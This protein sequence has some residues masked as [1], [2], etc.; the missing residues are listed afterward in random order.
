MLILTR[1]VN[2]DIRIG[3]DIVITVTDIGGGRVQLGITAPR[4]VPVSRG[5][6]AADDR[7]DPPGGEG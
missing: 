2:E 6:L 3:Q 5:E 7:R 4:D 1:R